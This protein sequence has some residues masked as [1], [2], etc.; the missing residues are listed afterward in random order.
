MSFLNTLSV[1]YYGTTVTKLNQN[2]DFN[3]GAGELTAVILVND[4]TLEGYADA[5]ATAMTLAGGQ[6]YTAVINRTTRKITISSV[7]TFSLLSLTGTHAGSSP[8]TMLGYTTVS[9][10][11]GTN[12]YQSQNGTGSEYRPQLL[13]NEYT[14][15]EDFEVKESAVVN[16]SVNGVVQTLQFGDGQR[17]NCN[18]RGATDLLGIKTDPFFE[19]ATGVQSLRDF[20]KYLIT[21]AKIEFMPDVDV[22]GTFYSLLLEGTGADKNGTKFIISNMNGANK[23][24]ESG[25]LTFRK[26]IE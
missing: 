8:W 26:V 12:T 3:E 15:P 24:F 23:F 21:K 20:M 1:F 11:T 14:Q 22:R 25:T 18:L 7:A 13:M 16:I 4:Y 9:D 2:L 5:V 6:T 10:K 17:M 19:N